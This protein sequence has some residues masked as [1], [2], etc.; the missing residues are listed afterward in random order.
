MNH[1]P[2]A[3]PRYGV[4]PPRDVSA[5][6]PRRRTGR[7]RPRPSRAHRVGTSSAPRSGTATGWTVPTT[8]SRPCSAHA[9]CRT[10]QSSGTTL[11]ASMATASVRFDRARRGQVDGTEGC[12]GDE[13]A[14]RVRPPRGRHALGLPRQAKRRRN[15]TARRVRQQPGQ[16]RPRPPPTTGS[17]RSARSRH[18]LLG[19]WIGGEP[20]DLRSRRRTPRR[21][22]ALDL[23]G[24]SAGT[25]GPAARWGRGHYSAL[26]RP[27]VI[28]CAPAGT[29][30]TGC[31]GTGGPRR[32][33]LVRGPSCPSVLS[34]VLTQPRYPSSGHSSVPGSNRSSVSVS[35][36]RPFGRLGSPSCD[37]RYG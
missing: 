29:I 19:S 31:P 22:R 37:P 10:S 13:H 8:R 21:P 33:S 16:G 36:E 28:M 32:R 34:G 7:R 17:V 23:P 24:R 15:V 4:H 27:P 30:R 25:R 1:R 20:S 2:G 9:S 18:S 3:L 26:P 12:Q 11:S 6:R 5:R 14:P 35:A